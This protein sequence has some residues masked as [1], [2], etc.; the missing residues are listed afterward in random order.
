VTGSVIERMDTLPVGDKVFIFKANVTGEAEYTFA[1]EGVTADGQRVQ[2]SAAHIAVS[3]RQEQESPA[4]MVTPPPP[5]PQIIAQAEAEPADGGTQPI[6][7]AGMQAAG[8]I[9]GNTLLVALFIVGVL[10][11][12]CIIV[13]IALFMKERARRRYMRQEALYDDVYEEQGEY[14]PRYE[15]AGAARAPHDDEITRPV[16]PRRRSSARE[17]VPTR[18]VNPKHR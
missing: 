3:I 9:A 5:D 18:P 7:N 13:L 12:L 8:G 16:A 1:V 17:D 10:I 14:V 4:P 6:F 11:V 2:A 15:P